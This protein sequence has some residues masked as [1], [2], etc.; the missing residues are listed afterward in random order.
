M[1]GENGKKWKYIKHFHNR[2]KYE[3]CKKVND[4]L[5]I[6]IYNINRRSLTNK[7]HLKKIEKH[8][9]LKR[10]LGKDMKK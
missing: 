9:Q 7:E 3:E 10:K 4:K 8:Q 2:M 6:N 1:R 5:D